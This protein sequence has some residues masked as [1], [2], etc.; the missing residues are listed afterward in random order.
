[1]PLV[2]VAVRFDDVRLVASGVSKPPAAARN[3]VLFEDFEHVDEGWGPFLYAFEGPM[4]THLSQAHP[5]YT[6]DTLG[7]EFSL[8]SWNEDVAGLVYRTVPATL[9]LKPDTRYRVSFRYRCDVPG[10][11]SF[12]AGSDDAGP[13][14][15]RRWALPVGG[16]KTARFTAS[17]TTGAQDDWFLGMAKDQGKGVLVIDD[18]LV[19]EIPAR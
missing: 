3:V 4:Q 16:W 18:L 17:F 14:A 9:A 12:S 19:Q 15:A 8:K 7:G 11:F 1:M 13:A 6:D 5:P 10:R 2:D